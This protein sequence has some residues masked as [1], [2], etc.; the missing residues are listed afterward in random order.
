MHIKTYYVKCEIVLSRDNSYSIYPKYSERQTVDT[1]IRRG[2]TRSLI[3]IQLLATH[4]TIFYT[5]TNNKEFYICQLS[6]HVRQGVKGPEYLEW[7]TVLDSI[8]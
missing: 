2:R 3:R 7:N 5:L 8:R 1:Q 6:V 4:P